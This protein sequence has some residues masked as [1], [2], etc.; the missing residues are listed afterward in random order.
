[1]LAVVAGFEDVPMSM[2]RRDVLQLSLAAAVGAVSHPSR[3]LSGD[4]APRPERKGRLKQAGVQWCYGAPLEELAEVCARFGA[5]GIDVVHPNDWPVLQRHGLA[6][7]LTPCMERGFGT[8]R[9]LNRVEDHASHI[10]VIRERIELSAAAGYRNILVFSGNRIDGLSD[11]DGLR[12]C[13]DALRQ[14]VG[15]AGDKGQVL[16]M[17]IL[18]SKR[19]HP[20]YMF[21]RM[22]WGLDLVQAVGS[23]SFKILYDI[24]HAQIME[25]DV[26]QTIRD[27]H[28]H[29][30]HYHTAGVPGRHNLDKT[31]E[32]YYPAIMEAIAETGFD[33]V[34]AQEFL[35]VGDRATALL[36]AFALCDV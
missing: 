11:A 24:Y 17:E 34:V 12:N 9:G 10:E 5:A 29:I 18:N 19:D 1:V 35:P 23:S 6:S 3:A 26:I 22:S 15:L 7:T 27:H 2:P 8:S 13:A 21:D 30:G 31:Q 32:L 25:G 4:A 16:L 33:G 36:N 28:D 14:I 20:G